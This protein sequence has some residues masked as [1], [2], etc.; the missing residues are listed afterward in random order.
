MKRKKAGNCEDDVGDMVN[1]I[2]HG[3]MAWKG[4]EG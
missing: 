3:G 4:L 1:D 2:T